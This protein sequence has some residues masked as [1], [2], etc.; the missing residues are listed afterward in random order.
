M[1]LTDNM[2]DIFMLKHTS[3]HASDVGK[4]NLGLKEDL[5]NMT[6]PDNEHLLFIDPHAGLTF[7]GGFKKSQNMKIK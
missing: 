2:L 5:H 1:A 4:R 3:E 6:H 7:T